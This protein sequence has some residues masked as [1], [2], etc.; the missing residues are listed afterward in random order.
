MD[1]RRMCPH[2][3]AFITNKD[4]VCPYCNERVGARAVDRRTPTEVLGG[5]I[6]H[7]RFATMLLLLVNVGLYLVTTLYSYRSGNGGISA[8]DS[9]TLIIFGASWGPGIA[10]GQWWRLVTAGF[11]HGGLFHIL[12]NMWVLFDLGAE[13]EEVY[14]PAR[15]WV[16]YFVTTIAGFRLSSW[17]N[18]VVPSVGASAALFGLI[19]AM[20]ALGLQNNNAMGKAIRGLYIR[21]AVYGLIISV[22]M[23]YVDIAAHIGGLAAGFGLGYLAGTP[24]L[25]GSPSERLWNAASWVCLAATGYCF[26][27][28]YLFFRGIGS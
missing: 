21:W 15:L 13:V 20:I 26:L 18:P 12:M 6:P 8:I 11:L 7:A 22:L 28:M 27:S 23:P 17:W 14:G 4:R 19:G 9:R 16:F 24:R 25:E 2:C 3:R 10:A 1:S 5:F